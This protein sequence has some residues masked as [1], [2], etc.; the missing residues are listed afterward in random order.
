MANLAGILTRLRNKVAREYLYPEI[1]EL[2]KPRINPYPFNIEKKARARK[3]VVIPI[4][5][6]GSLILEDV[7]PSFDLITYSYT[8]D[9][10][11]VASSYFENIKA[12]NHLSF[13]TEFFGQSLKH[14]VD[15][16][17]KEACYD[18]IMFL[19]GDVM[20]SVSSINA[21][22]FIADKHGLDVYQPSLSLDSFYSHK[23]LLNK[24]GLILEEVIFTES[25]M[26]GL[27]MRALNAIKDENQFPISS[28]G[29][30]T[31]L[32]PYIIKKRNWINPCVVHMSIARHC[33]PVNSSEMTFSNGKSAM[34]EMREMAQRYPM[35]E[36]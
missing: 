22:L 18:L 29:I 9:S 20:I 34:S 6:F 4:E 25:M 19:S 17:A 36:E 8:G 5:S 32:L 24:P 21:C 12:I 14:L 10:E 33:R 23:H 27:S 28:Y 35:L 11:V 1:N 13:K 30:D 15:N 7:P 16:I 26:L 31:H 2:S 3:L